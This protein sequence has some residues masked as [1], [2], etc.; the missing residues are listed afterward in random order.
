MDSHRAPL[1]TPEVYLRGGD[2]DAAAVVQ[3]EA[4][5]VDRIGNSLIEIPGLQRLECPASHIIQGCRGICLK[6]FSRL[7]QQAVLESA[8][9]YRVVGSRLGMCRGHDKLQKQQQRPEYH[10]EGGI[11]VHSYLLLRIGSREYSNL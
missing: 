10:S 4:N 6:K 5:P 8:K 3:H 7:P 9:L 1:Q 2:I 11:L